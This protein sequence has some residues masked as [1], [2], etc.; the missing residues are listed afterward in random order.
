MQW[1]RAE[2]AG[3]FYPLDTM[4]MVSAHV[5]VPIRPFLSLARHILP[6]LPYSVTYPAQI[7]RLC[8]H[9]VFCCIIKHNRTTRKLQKKSHHVN[10]TIYLTQLVI[11]PPACYIPQCYSHEK[12]LNILNYMVLPYVSGYNKKKKHLV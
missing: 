7:L 6:S 8:S 4:T 10:T 11:F 2:I 9:T 3:P 5:Y 1:S 12:K